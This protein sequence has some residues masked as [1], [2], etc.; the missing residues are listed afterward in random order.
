VDCYDYQGNLTTL[1][2]LR[3]RYGPI[4]IQQADPPVDYVGF[5]WKVKALR[6][7]RGTYAAIHNRFYDE[8][9]NNW[10]Q[11]WKF[12]YTWPDAPADP[13]AGPLEGLPAGLVEGRAVKGPVKIESDCTK[14]DLTMGGGSYY[15][16]PNRGP[17][18]E[19]GY[20]SGTSSDVVWG[21]GMLWA[22]NHDHLDVD[23]ELV[24]HEPGTSPEPEPEPEPEPT[25]DTRRLS[26]H[27]QTLP[28]WG[29]SFVD[30][31][32]GKLQYV[33]LMDPP[34]DNPFPGHPELKII[35]RTYLPDAQANEMVA[36]GAAGAREW[37]NHWKT[38]YQQRPWVHAWEAPN[39]PQPMNSATFRAALDAFTVELANLMH[40]I[41]YLLVGHCWSVGNPEVEQTSEFKKS[42]A[43]ID[44]LGVHEYSAPTMYH[45]DGWYTL[46]IK[47]VIQH[48]RA[49]GCRVP[50]VLVTE[51]GVDGGVISSDLAGK[52]WRYFAPDGVVAEDWYM[53][54]LKWY[55]TMLPEEVR[56]ATVFNAGGYPEWHSFEVSSGLVDRIV[57]W[58]KT[59]SGPSPAYVKG[60]DISQYQDGHVNWQAAVDV[61]NKFT[62]L[63]S[64]IGL[65]LDKGFLTRHLPE[66]EGK[67]LFRFLYH[68]LDP[69]KS[70]EY[71][72]RLH[73]ACCSHFPVSGGAVM[74]EMTPIK[75]SAVRTFVETWFSLTDVPPILYANPNIISILKQQGDLSFLAPCPLW[76]AHYGVSKPSVPSPWSKWTFWQTGKQV[77]LLADRDRARARVSQED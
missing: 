15:Q 63:R 16:P 39:E 77:D 73:L 48:L 26:L 12:C 70:A 71:Q 38:F 47:K 59:G 57:D 64:G 55:D 49:Q 58:V 76:L 14:F 6:E 11:A 53:E 2:A 61:G 50:P 62:I 4:L 43:K 31:C 68:A 44:F 7:K 27:F 9:G 22:T 56:A 34:M 46:R 8:Q 29:K 33:K 3:Q 17:Y 66:S 54:Q 72:A 28:G 5:V 51:C 21:L 23:W 20:G 1:D 35:G 42:L 52:G 24:Y 10:G 67:P 18:A 37:F 40:S 45:G 75:L 74:V 60:F 41:N 25:P 13:N 30:R 32:A 65:E 19:W 69:T 36:R